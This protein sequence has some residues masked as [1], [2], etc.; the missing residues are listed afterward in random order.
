MEIFWI[1]SFKKGTLGMMKKPNGGTQ[2]EAD[3]N[4]LKKEKAT[5]LVCL[6]ASVEIEQLAL[7]KEAFYCNK[8]NIDFIHFPIKDYHLPEKKAYIAF[9]QKLDLLLKDNHKIVIHCH[10]GI[11]RTSTIVAGLLIKNNIHKDDV[12]EYISKKRTKTV[13][14]TNEQKD[15]VLSIKDEI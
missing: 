9:I 8:K 1:D 6:I 10:G 14:D 3:I 4:I 15:W 5:V 13:P 7:Q 11:G 2:L 12:F